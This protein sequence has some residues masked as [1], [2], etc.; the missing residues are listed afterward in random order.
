MRC[1]RRFEVA[2]GIAFAA[3]GL[4]QAQST[5]RVSVTSNGA[6]VHQ[7][8]EW[9][10]VS[11]DGRSV[12]F[13]SF[14]SNLV[15]HDNNGT[16]DVFVHDRDT[17]LTER[18][19]VDSSGAE[20][21]AIS[22]GRTALSADGTIVAFPS[23]ADNLVTGDTN[24]R[25]DVFV[26]DRTA[27]VTTRVSVDSSGTE[28][29]GTSDSPALSA[30]GQVIAFLSDATNLVA[31]DT[32]KRL[33]VFVHDRSTG[34]TERVSV[35]S[36]GTESNG[37]SNW[38][39]LSADGRFVSFESTATNLVSNDNN[40]YGDVFVH[41]R[42]TGITERVSVDSSGGEANHLS[43]FPSI[44]SDG[45][46]VA[47]ESVASNLVARDTNGKFDV[48][49]HDRATGVTK[50]VSVS[51]IGG[52]A[53]SDSG[54]PSISADGR[55]VA[56]DSSATNLIA[57][58][59]NGTV[60]VFVRDLT[61]GVTKRVSVDSSGVEADHGS[62]GPSISANGEVVAFA[63][64]ATNLIVG[65]RNG[66]PDIFVRDRCIALW[67]NYGS[68]FVGS[69]GVPALIPES[70]PELGSTLTVDLENSYGQATV[71]I[72]VVGFVRA[73]IPTSWG[74]ELL[75][76]PAFVLSVPLPAGGA[77]ASGS[78]VDDPALCDLTVDLQCLEVDPGSAKGVS[79]TPGLELVLGR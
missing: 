12:C 15:P 68:G 24:R 8:N 29:N 9:P 44:S 74:G 66:W 56:F 28:A 53:D 30:D 77:S 43:F 4:A 55:F 1:L 47:F 37:D 64:A 25:T 65:D 26:R 31:G 18:V 21:D 20:G 42:V 23:F 67:S 7:R 40:G 79:F 16:Y 63:S 36:A 3:T 38:L 70:D 58:D 69:R 50:R 52:E 71:G 48:F 51:T 39:C 61:T 22:Y 41:D 6:E 35:D 5:A 17:G 72:L 13:L 33:D 27:G 10:G 57:R 19:S 73:S 59:T 76:V 62:G 49:V 34:L 78:I 2:A 14:A 46:F 32:N 45:R 11:A 60:D 75:V 54:G